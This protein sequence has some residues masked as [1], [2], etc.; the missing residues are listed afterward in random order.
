MSLSY[1]T[2]SDEEENYASA[3]S[4]QFGFVLTLLFPNQKKKE[5]FITEYGVKDGDDK[6]KAMEVYIIGE[7]QDH[8]KGGIIDNS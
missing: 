7:D 3:D 2:S 6:W 8:C 5:W 4:N 1:S